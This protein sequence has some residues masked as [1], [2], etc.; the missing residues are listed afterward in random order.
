MF[1]K[2]KFLLNC[3]VCD[4][5]K[6]KE[7]DYGNFEQIMINADVLLVNER[8]RSVLNRLPVTLNYDK[9]V[10]LSDQIEA[11]VKVVNGSY[12]ITGSEISQEHIILVVNGD[13]KVAPGTAEILKKYEQ[14][15]VNGSAE[16]PK[17][18]E[19]FLSKMSV[20]GSATAYPDDCVLLKDPFTIDSYFPLRAKENG[21][22]YA[23]TAVVIKDKNVDIAKLAGKKVR[24]VTNRVILPECKIEESV[25]LFEERTEMIVVPDGMAIVYGDAVLNE[26]LIR[27]EGDSLFVYGNLETDENADMGV[28]GEML[29]KLVVKGKIML[30]REQLEAFEKLDAEYDEM[31]VV[32]NSRVIRNRPKT[33][34][35]R[36]LFDNSPEGIRAENIGQ[37]VIDEDV[38]PEV[39]LEKLTLKNCGGVDCTKEQESAV[40]AVAVN[41]AGIGEDSC[42]GMGDIAGALKDLAHTK[43]VNADSYIM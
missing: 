24:F 5:R 22:Y 12:E 38:T 21:S 18:L 19:G 35:D 7:E 37:L 40:T 30:K 36:K 2:K 43:M 11:A 9:M 20:N 29:K 14:I 31:E 34:L 27:K 26:E 8:S 16:Y 23:K 13:L 17:S 33:R 28:L 42:G 6:I 4:A 15:I 10:E 39:I 32:R 1:E 41:V 3:D 25:S